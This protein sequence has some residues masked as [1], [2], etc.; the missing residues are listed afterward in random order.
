MTPSTFQAKNTESNTQSAVQAPP[1]QGNLLSQSV[2]VSVSQV[3][4]VPAALSVNVSWPSSTNYW[5]QFSGIPEGTSCSQPQAFTPPPHPQG[6]MLTN[7]TQQTMQHIGM[8]TASAG[9]SSNITEGPHPSLP[10][11]CTS[12]LPLIATLPPPSSIQCS[13]ASFAQM[14]SNMTINSME[15][16]A[17]G[18]LPTAMVNSSSQAVSS[19][20]ANPVVPP[21]I[22]TGQSV[23]RPHPI[24]PRTVSS[25]VGIS[26]AVDWKP[27]MTSHPSMQ[28]GLTESSS[29]HHSKDGNNDAT[30]IVASMSENTKEVS[31]ELPK[32]LNT[33]VW[34]SVPTRA[35][36]LSFSDPYTFVV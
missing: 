28:A 33:E 31:P 23:L 9:S 36:V 17:S 32:A 2:G 24:I 11:V 25:T 8:N 13:N 10:T 3:P 19:S 26:S 27:S 5:H 7:T 16:K 1:F 18:T 15:N 20:G 21:V 29:S 14:F 4:T 30:I 12:S 6:F 34:L 22:H 35:C